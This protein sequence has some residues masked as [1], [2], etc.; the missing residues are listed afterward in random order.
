MSYTVE[1]V[2]KQVLRVLKLFSEC[3]VTVLSLCF[4]VSKQG[5]RI[6][7]KQGKLDAGTFILHAG[8][9]QNQRSGRCQTEKPGFR[10]FQV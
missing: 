10:V 8:V 7:W 4:T 2:L 3:I 6:A 9:H 1:N 5:F